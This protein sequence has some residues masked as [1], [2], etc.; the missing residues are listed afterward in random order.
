MQERVKAGLLSTVIAGSTV[1]FASCGLQKDSPDVVANETEPIVDVIPMDDNPSFSLYTNDEEHAYL[2]EVEVNP[3]IFT[4]LKDKNIEISH[5]PDITYDVL[6]AHSFGELEN[7]KGLTNDAVNLR[8]GPG[9]EFDIIKTLDTNNSVSLIAKSEN[10]WYM[11]QCGTNIG[12]VREDFIHEICDQ[13]ILQQMYHLPELIPMVQA[14]DNVNIRP[15][16]NTNEEEYSV[17]TVDH[18]LEMIRRLDNGWYEVR[19]GDKNAYVCGDYVRESYAIAG[20]F[21]KMVYIH[22]DTFMSD[23]PYGVPATY[24][25]QFESAKVYCEIEGYYYVECNGYVGFVPKADCTDL[26]G[27]FVIVDISS[28][29]LMLV[30]GNEILLTTNVVTGKDSSP[31]DIGLHDI[32]AKAT[33]SWLTGADYSVHVDYWIPFNGGEG[34]HD[35]SWRDYFGGTLYHDSGSHG[36]VNMSPEVT[37]TV[38]EAVSVGD[39]VLVK[40]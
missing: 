20:P 22:Q 19:Y 3:D 28:Q 39:K 21:D 33:D 14:M 5:Y 8:K 1:L 13:S 9:I 26:T 18:S 10:G 23:E 7:Q 38:Y 4:I 27:T 37:P 34:L 32:D 31:T 35:A 2:G 29:T 15:Q 24:I 25:P 30:R 40:R 6:S 12:F 17:L 36:C 16:P 11:I